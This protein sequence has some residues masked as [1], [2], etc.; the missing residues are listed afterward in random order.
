MTPFP[1]N[2]SSRQPSG[3]GERWGL[4]GEAGSPP[5]MSLGA[6]GVPWATWSPVVSNV[7][8]LLIGILSFGCSVASCSSA[9]SWL[10]QWGPLSTRTILIPLESRRVAMNQE[11]WQGPWPAHWELYGEISQFTSSPSQSVCSRDSACGMD[12]NW[13]VRI[14]EEGLTV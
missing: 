5:L 1:L 2:T 6:V 7:P 8:S 3:P 10:P 11:V 13:A 12:T 4:P 9:S 14:E